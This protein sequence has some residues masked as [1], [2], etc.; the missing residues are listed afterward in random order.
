MIATYLYGIRMGTVVSAIASLQTYFLWGQPYAAILLILETIW[1]GIGLHYKNQNKQ[2]RN[3]VLLVLSYWLCL[4][5]PC[6]FLFYYFFLKFGINSVILVTLKQVINGAFNALI[7]HLCLGY[8]PIRQWLRHQS[9]DRHHLTIQQMLFHALLAFVFFPLLAIAILTGYQALN[10]IENEISNQLH[11]NTAELVL[12]L[13]IWH[14]NNLRT[15]QEIAIL[16]ADDKSWERLQFGTTT[17]GKVNPSLLR[18][19]VTDVQSNILAAFPNIS[20]TDRAELS[21]SIGSSDL[22]QTTRT[23]LSTAFSNIHNNDHMISM[24]HVDMAVPVVRQNRFQGIV[25]GALDVPQI[26]KILAKSTPNRKVE[27]FLID[28]HKEIISVSSPN[29]QLGNVFDVKQGGEVRSFKNDQIQ[30]IPHIKGAALMTRWRKSYYIQQ[31]TI[32]AQNPWVLVVRLS[33]VAYIDALEN[34]Y[35]YILVIVLTIILLATAVA[36]SLSLRLVKPIAKLMRLTTEL[37]QNLSSESDFV[38][39]SKSFA[40]IDTLGYNFQVMASALREKFQEIQQAN[41]NL[42]KRVQERTEQLLKSELRLERITDA[43]PSTVYQFRRDLDGSYSFPFMSQGAYD[44]FEL[45][46]EECC[47]DAAKA[48]DLVID[49]DLEKLFE[50]I[51]DSAKTETSWVHEFRLRT[52][53]GKFKWVSGR[54]QPMR[55]S[56]DSIIWNGILTD[57]THL[58]EI[59]SALQKSE[60]RWQLAIQAADDG[61]WDW[62]L[63]TGIIFRSARWRTILGLDPHLD[64]EENLDWLSIIHPDDRENVL[65]AHARY[66]NR[67]V[68]RY[69]MEHRMRH[70]DGSYRWILTKAMAL[71]DEQ[72]KPLRL[73]GANSDVTDRKLT[74]AALEKRESYLAMLVDVQHYLIAESTQDYGRIL[75]LLGKV[76]DFSSVKLFTCEKDLSD[77]FEEEIGIALGTNLHVDLYAAWYSQGIHPPQASQQTTFIQNLISCQWLQRLAQGELFNVSASTVD[78][79]EKSILTSKGLLSILVMPIMVNGK[80]WGFLSFHDY[81]SDRLRDHAEISLLTIAA[82]SLSLH[83]ERQQAQIEMLQ[84]MEAAQ[85]ANQAKSEF[86]ATMSHEIRTPM[87]AVIGMASLLLD[88]DLNHEQHEFAEII[89]SSGDNLLTII[90]D[91][92]DFSKIESGRFSLDNHPFNLRSCIED[93]LD[94]LAGYA[95]S[96]DI[97]L[98]YCITTDVPDW[99]LGDITRLRQILVNLLSNAIKFT[100]KGSVSLRVSVKDGLP[101]HGASAEIPYQLLFAVQDTGIGIPRDR[102]DRLF[103]PFSQVDSST[104][105][106]YGGTGLGL[107]ISKHLTQIMGGDIYCESTVGIGSIFSFTISTFATQPESIP[108][109]WEPSLAGQRLLILEDHDVNREELINFAQ[110]L[111]M[112]VMATPYSHQAIAWLQEGQKFDLAIVD[113]CLPH[114]DNDRETDTQD[115]HNQCD[116][117]A[118]IQ[119]QSRSLPIILLMPHCKCVVQESDTLISLSKPIKRSLL[120]SALLK[121]N[122]RSQSST[123]IKQ[124]EDSIFDENFAAKFPLKI[125]I[126]EDNIVNQKV[127]TRF[128]NRLGYRVDVVAN[129]LEALEAIYRQNYDVI[130]MDI[131]MPEMDGITATKKIIAEFPQSPWIIALTANAAQVDRDIC[132][133]SGMQDYLSKPLKVQDLTRSLE[134]AYQNRSA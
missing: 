109:Q 36:N 43:V 28:R 32:D 83:L 89:R 118:L 120:Y 84:A 20:D 24:P 10:Y 65:Q 128:L 106:Q 55:Q 64:D 108:P 6:C 130:L 38:W 3:M 78:A 9:S 39:Q 103:K 14:Q 87:N 41:L 34:L 115:P 45:T 12:D 112:E 91:I 101:N 100:L 29:L 2:P 116:M 110:L 123:P 73:V 114:L 96:K 126:A 52:P 80:F 46:A 4:G 129:G 107:A 40:E 125:L 23:T 86:L 59:E 50:S 18:I 16:A 15:L 31:A 77:S 25:I 62:N 72:G 1:V 5:A 13:K 30:W 35:T 60:E 85:A 48:F 66:L 121:L 113:A 58:K 63:E 11:A 97:E 44:L 94:L 131:H 71:W 76:S 51:E 56:D 53:S 49:E 33:P 90:N 132:L 111:K 82:S 79:S 117:G 93:C 105:R 42:E 98:V 61:I 47:Q 8:L 75:E 124:K 70:Q 68:P 122:K 21:V 69:I 37:Q 133:E 134:K 95:V 119:M 67:E 19:Y 22:F 99:I 27:A 17:L 57:I 54:S 102:Y 74:I 26:D 92:L 81:H 104:T 7:A 88:T 127:A